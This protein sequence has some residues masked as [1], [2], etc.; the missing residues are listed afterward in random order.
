MTRSAYGL[1]EALHLV[2]RLRRDAL[3]VGIDPRDLHVA[4]R[5]AIEIDVRVA[6]QTITPVELA[7]LDLEGLALAQRTVAGEAADEG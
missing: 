4:L 6:V 7:T 2:R 3:R 1:E 5:F